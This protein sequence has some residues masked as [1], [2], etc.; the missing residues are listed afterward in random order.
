MIFQTIHRMGKPRRNRPRPVMIRFAY[1]FDRHCLGSQ[2]G[3]W[4]ARDYLNEDLP[5][6]YKKTG[7][8]M[9]FMKTARISRAKTT[10]VA[11][12]VKIGGRLYSVNQM[13]EL[14][15]NCNSELACVKE[16]EKSPSFFG[17]YSL[18]S[19]F[20]PCQFGIS[21]N[22]T[23]TTMEQFIYWIFS[24]HFFQYHWTMV[25]LELRTI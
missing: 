20:Y 18:L 14:P 7:F 19:N 6:D 3:I 1:L 25:N 23:Y 5:E 2:V 21:R 17:R 15:C 24:S 8:L 11:N 16:K 13:K 22:T 4:K 12:K 9:P 10:M